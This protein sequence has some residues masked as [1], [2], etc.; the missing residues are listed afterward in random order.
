MPITVTLAVLLILSTTGATS[1]SVVFLTSVSFSFEVTF[2][3]FVKVLTSVTLTRAV[4]HNST[5]CVVFSLEM[6]HFAPLLYLPYEMTTLFG[7][8]L[9]PASTNVRPSG[10]L[11]MTIK[12]VALPA[13]SFPTTMVK[14]TTV[15]LA[16]GETSTFLV[17]FRITGT[18]SIS[19]LFG[20]T[21]SFSLHVTL[22]SLVMMPAFAVF[23]RAVIHN[24]TMELFVI[25]EMVH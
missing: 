1:T 21:V 15:L 16:T 23:T 24:S 22:T 20:T 19:V 18:T 2:T 12:S 25:F 10:N 4:I 9:T 8:N 11:S 17:M 3:L 6:F 7:S 13:L 5:V 14:F